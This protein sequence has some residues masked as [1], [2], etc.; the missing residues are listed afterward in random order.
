MARSHHRAFRAA[1]AGFTAIALGAVSLAAAGPAQ[2]AV[3]A[4]VNVTTPSAV[5]PGASFDVT[6]DVVCPN[7][8][9][10]TGA[11][12]A[13][14]QVVPDIAAA[15][16]GQVTDPNFETANPALGTN[17]HHWANTYPF[18]AP[19]LATLGSNS[20]TVVTTV[21][22]RPC[23]NDSIGI[24]KTSTIIV[25]DLPAA[26]SITSTTPGD[27][28]ASVTYSPVADPS[29]APVTSYEY[30]VNG[31]AA[32]SAGLTNP[33]TALGLINET[34]NT[35]TVR[36][37]NIAGP[38][39]WSAAANVTAVGPPRVPTSLAVTP[40]NATLSITFSAPPTPINAIDTYQYSTDGGATWQNLP[41]LSTAYDI[42]ALSTDGTT[43]L[44]N[45][46]AYNVQVR[47]HNSLGY[48]AATASVSGTPSTLPEAPAG[49]T[50]TSANNALDVS[51]TAPGNGGS[52]ITDYQYSTDSGLT[53]TSAGSTTLPLHITTTSDTAAALTNGQQYGV[54]VEAVNVNG[55]GAPSTVVVGTP[56][57]APDKPTIVVYPADSTVLVA[58]SFASDGGVPVTMAQC[59][60]DGGAAVDGTGVMAPDSVSA[61]FLMTGLT[62]GHT[63]SFICRVGNG[64][65]WSPWSDAASATPAT[66]P[67]APTLTSVVPGKDPVTGFYNLTVNFTPGT[68]N[69]SAIT[70]YS[71]Y[72]DGLL[73]TDP[74][75][76]ATSF[77]GS[78]V[79]MPKLPKGDVHVIT[80]TA[81]NG[82]GESLASNA[83]TATVGQTLVTI[84]AS[85]PAN[86]TY[87]TTL[88]AVTWSSNPS[89]AAGAWTTQPTCAIYTTSDTS[90]TT[91]LTGTQNAGTY[92]THC[93][94]GTATLYYPAA[95]VD[96]SLTITKATSS[97][98]ISCTPSV[99]YT[100]AAL[101]PCSVTIT[102]A[103]GLNTTVAL[104]PTDYTN[105]TN[106]GTATASY[107]FAGDANHNGSNATQVTFTITK[108]DST[109]TVSC[110]ASVVYTGSAQTPCT[111]TVTGP[112]LTTMGTI[113]YTNNT[114]VGTASATY[115][116][117]G[118]ANLS[119]STGSA[120]FAITKANSI[121]TITCPAS[122]I[123]N[124]AAQTPCSGTITAPGISQAATPLAYANNT[125][126]GT[127]SVSYTYA[128]TANV[129]SS[130][131]S[132]T[133]AITKA[134][135]STVITCPASVVATGSA[136]TPCTATSTGV[137]GLSVTTTV[138]YTNNID[139]GT[140]TATATF[141]G[142]SNHLGSTA[143]PV[144]FTIK[145]PVTVT[146]ASPANITYGASLPAITWSSSPSTSAGDWTTEPTCAVYATSDTSY[147]TPL[148]GTQ[149]AGT[150][151][152]HCSGGVA[153]SYSASSY[154]NGHLT[155]DKA[156][157]SVVITCPT[158]VTFT[159]TAR[160]PCSATVT[161]IGGL[162]TT[163]GVA[164][165]ANTHAGTATADSTWAGDS[166]HLAS[167][168]TQV[169]FTIDQAPSTTVVTCSGPV[170]ATGS[171]LTPCT[172]TT[173]GAGGLNVSTS[174][175][176]SNN[177]IAGTAS[178]AATF[179]GDADHSGSVGNATF[180]IVARSAV[181]V[182]T[183]S[184]SGS[185]LAT[186]R[187]YRQVLTNPGSPAATISSTTPRA[188]VIK[189]S[190]VYFL[191]T[192]TCKVTI[193]Q[194]GVVYKNLT[195]AVSKANRLTAPA[196]AQSIKAVN[197]ATTSTA[198]SR[199]AQAQL[200]AMLPALRRAKVVIIY[201]FA[202]GRGS[203]AANRS[204]ARAK[205]V[206]AYLT[207]HGVSV[208]SSGGYGT[209]IAAA[210]GGSSDRVDIAT[211]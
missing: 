166:N 136:L 61:S 10:G 144:S 62:N 29:G 46:T 179:A 175:D 108:A 59:Q 123:Y 32:V 103:G 5:A 191:V 45:G 171:P 182:P 192:G 194:G 97:A 52:A 83:I 111:V 39:P 15:P 159:G 87:G 148:T 147:T 131:G 204:T 2:A 125:N 158:N 16:L 156:E 197:F 4:T 1:A 36:A 140:A 135:S 84:T 162:S 73:Y 27:G 49:V 200:N 124:G 17:P 98:A 146:A 12:T 96:G 178:A 155:I 48:G 105:N 183:I 44:T 128:G 139:A 47:A 210:K 207:A 91:P 193:I 161:G 26:P 138:N 169:S 66:V 176:Y 75:T 145:A 92:V 33:F 172:A 109:T 143:T 53:F 63:Y 64:A 186:A 40:G 130:T 181:V 34:S 69:G 202:S 189:D 9:F 58:A 72:E 163:A 106:V 19:D 86:I 121:V 77:S 90:Y 67:A 160:T 110:P 126:T 165:G 199:A 177:V 41:S 206:V 95:Y 28:Q 100:S 7:S 112:G 38:G 122:V 209:S 164:Y 152:T 208:A 35:I 89:T 133:F 119:S 151:V 104:A 190:K 31:A 157:S 21:T 93:T 149:H 8:D 118:T 180:T 198:L 71:I 132:A 55:V 129:N 60:L 188:C 107:T 153:A 3:T 201:G 56:G 150:Y 50:V 170:I 37:V 85:S 116:Y 74:D 184:W 137:G 43:A 42:T 117:A 20:L 25:A 11:I 70:G 24:A 127:A 185:N 82:V 18:T 174:V 81:T 142:D 13:D 54:V 68:D 99:T 203:V 88:P 14:V 173:T 65:G 211:P 154:V 168:A 76:N 141:A 187:S 205:A 6:V 30:S 51:F 78:P 57:L 80:V 23:V 101:T 167:T 94:G 102:G 120:N 113:T 196:K 115:N 134:N 114:N 195:A 79:V 22:G